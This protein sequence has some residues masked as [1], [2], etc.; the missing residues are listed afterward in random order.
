[1]SYEILFG[2]QVVDEAGYA[3]YRAAIVPFLEK[4]GAEFRY[5]F[6]VSRVLKQA[7]PAPMNRVFTIRFRDRAAKD[8]L[9][10][11]PGYLAVKARLFTPAVSDT[12][13]LAEYETA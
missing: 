3:A 1:M 9:F 6:V 7:T 2:V 11:D 10:S 4:V 5:D 13:R 12:T 8:A